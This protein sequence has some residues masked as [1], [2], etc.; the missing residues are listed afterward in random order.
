M[1]SGAAATTK[2]KR[3]RKKRK[4]I[5]GR[6]PQLEACRADYATA[7]S[8]AATQKVAELCCWLAETTSLASLEVV[9]TAA[10][11]G[12]AAADTY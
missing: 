11:A 1:D 6:Q 12:A 9:L 2:K 5:A 8:T 10:A 4:R 3:R 7:T